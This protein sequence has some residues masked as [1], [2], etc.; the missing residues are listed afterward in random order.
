MRGISGCRKTLIGAAVLLS[1]AAGSTA[2][3]QVRISQV[4]AGGGNAGAT[5]SND[6]VELFNAGSSSASLD[7]LTIQYASATGTTW[8]IQVLP[9][10]ALN[11]GQ[12]FLVQLGSG[13]ANGVPLPVTP[14][15]TGTIGMG[16]SAGK[17]ALAQQLTALAG[18]CPTVNIVDFVGYGTT[19]NC[20]EGSSNAPAP[21]LNA[22]A[23]FRA[24][25]GCQDTNV[26]GADFASLAVN[27][28]NTMS[29]TN[30]CTPSTPPSGV[31][32]S[33]PADPCINETVILTVAVTPTAGRG[34]RA[35]A[36]A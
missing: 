4:Y 8:A 28:R 36:G 34:A 26:N 3:G 35:G 29:P 6:F 27:P 10:V 16:A 21:G 25:N 17:V 22:N 24:N 19:A 33:T 14:D 5:Y 20:S 31:G 15:V 23:L 11:P 32:S 2:N 12:Y 1:I 7:G 9:N 30:S 18:T 13:G